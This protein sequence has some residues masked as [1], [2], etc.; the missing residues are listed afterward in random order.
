MNGIILDAVLLDVHLQQIKPNDRS[1][2]RANLFCISNVPILLIS[3]IQTQINLATFSD[4]V[5]V[6]PPFPQM[7]LN[8]YILRQGLISKFQIHRFSMSVSL[9]HCVRISKI[10]VSQ[11]V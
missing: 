11:S 6:A 5:V 3:S 1:R 10:Q 7:L 4:N 8:F 2:D 9:C